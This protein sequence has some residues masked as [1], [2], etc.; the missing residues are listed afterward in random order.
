MTEVISFVFQCYSGRFKR[1]EQFKVMMFLSFQLNNVFKINNPCNV[2]VN[3]KENTQ[4][5][6]MKIILINFDIKITLKIDK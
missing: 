4:K 2:K 6:I 5:K 1:T 3:K